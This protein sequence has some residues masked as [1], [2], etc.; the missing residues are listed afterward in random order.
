MMRLAL[1]ASAIICTAQLSSPVIGYVRTTSS[2]LRPVLGVAGAFVLGEALEREVLSASF[3]S[4]SGLVKK[5]R[6]VLFYRAGRLVSRHEAPGGPA[7]F[8]FTSRGEPATIRFEN[9]ECHEWVR[10]AFAP[11][12]Q[13]TCDNAAVPD[14]VADEWVAIRSDTGIAL[15]RGD[16]I[17]Q[18]PE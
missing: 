5:D 15:K 14:R 13:Y 17:W 11:A 3:T 10:G 9:G 18:L 1:F 2:E 8:S 6:E 7:V 12:A 16:R 4:V